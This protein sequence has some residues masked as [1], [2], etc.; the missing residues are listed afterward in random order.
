MVNTRSDEIV[1]PKDLHLGEMKPLSS[2]DD[3]P[4]PSAVNQ[5]TYNIDSHCVDAQWM[6]PDSSPSNQCKTHSNL[7][8]VPKN[9]NCNAWQCSNS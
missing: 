1:L 2:I 8:P 3:P 7:G 5:V 4:K 6:Q 9:L